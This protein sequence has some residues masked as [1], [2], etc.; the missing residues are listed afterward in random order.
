MRTLVIFLCISLL[1]FAAFGQCES[2]IEMCKSNF[3][4]EYI[5]DGQVY[6]ALLYN[7]QIA[8]F[9]MSM[10]GGNTYRISTGSGEKANNLIFRIY[11]KEK[12]LLFTNSDF[13]NAAYWDF[14]VES[15][16]DC[17]IEAQLDLNKVDS[18]C[19]VVLVGFK[20]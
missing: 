4:N 11:D 5:S 13:S 12:N 10:F 7:D 1:S 9:E 2:T 18:G 14:V 8:E 15:T 6:R 20:E 16:I 17:T 3:S 19:A